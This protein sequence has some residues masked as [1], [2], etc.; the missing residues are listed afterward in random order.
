MGSSSCSASPSTLRFANCGYST[1]LPSGVGTRDETPA[2]PTEE[3]D[4]E[5]RRDETSKIEGLIFAPRDGCMQ[6]CVA[7]SILGSCPELLASSD[8]GERCHGRNRK[9]GRDDMMTIDELCFTVQCFS[10]NRNRSLAFRG[11][12]LSKTLV[13]RPSWPTVSATDHVPTPPSPF[14]RSRTQRKRLP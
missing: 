6:A 4:R 5:V 2:P 7:G 12:D 8:A 9:S 11:P 3:P 13:S 10:S 14:C 1:A